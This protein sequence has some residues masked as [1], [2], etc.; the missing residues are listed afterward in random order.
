MPSPKSIFLTKLSIF[1]FLVLQS[2]HCQ[3]NV[4][5]L[6]VADSLFAQRSYKE[7]LEIYQAN[8]Q[9]GIYSPAMLL[10]MAF[11]TEGIGD[12]EMATLYLS[13]YYDLSPNPQTI[14]KIK[15]LTGQ[16]ELVGYEVSDAMRFILF[17][18]EFK[19]IIVGG[20][21]VILII[22]LIFLWSKGEKLTEAR[23]YWPSVLLITLIFVTNN[24]LKSQNAALVTKS[25]TLIVS[26][27]SAG[28]EMVDLVE[29]GHR[30]KIRSSKDI[31]YEVEWKEKIAY[32]RKDN[33][34]RL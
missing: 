33:V 25:P 32:I 31:W 29:P 9:L 27:P 30:V 18:V 3:A 23:F 34:T 16:S 14:T 17:L 7:A 24:F 21:T 5:Q 1:F 4:P 28:G 12:K 2:I 26:K 6:L 8:Y 19:E 11:I 15:S 20:L 22:S 10:K 13:K